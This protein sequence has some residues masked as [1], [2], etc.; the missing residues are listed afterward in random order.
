MNVPFINYTFQGDPLRLPLWWDTVVQSRIQMMVT[1]LGN[2]FANDTSLALVYVTQ[3]T[4]NGIEGHFNGIPMSTMYSAG[5]TPTKWINA[6]KQTTYF[7][8][9]AFPSKAIAFE[10][11][12]VDTTE[13][14]PQTIINDLYNDTSLR[15][16]VGAALWWLSGKTTYQPD[17]LNV[18][19]NFPGDKYAQLIGNSRQPWRFKDSSIAT[20]FAQAKQL[21]I[22]YIEPWLYEYQHH[23][24]DSLLHDFNIWADSTFVLTGVDEQDF[25][26]VEIY[27]LSQNYPNLFNPS[28]TLSFSIHHS[29]FVI[30]KVYDVLGR[31]VR[32]LVNENLQ[33]GS[34]EVTFDARGLAS[35]TYFYRLQ[36]KEFTPTKRMLLIR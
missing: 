28:T 7:F 18:L 9:N 15:G 22:R 36:T 24:I 25:A 17:L 26:V 10:V 13:V 6:A 4:T 30:L 35:G 29:S 2:Q 21:R 5:F 16:R 14:I 3:M 12:E 23:T 20:A 32:R 1:A 33:A 19:Q 11:H 31:E 8:A 34:Y 27:H